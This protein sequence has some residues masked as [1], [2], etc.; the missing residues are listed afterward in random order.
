MRMYSDEKGEIL[1]KVYSPGG[2][3]PGYAPGCLF[4]RQVGRNSSHSPSLAWD[5]IGGDK[6]NFSQEGLFCPVFC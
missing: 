2:E 6:K 4:P 1:V 3:P 5:A